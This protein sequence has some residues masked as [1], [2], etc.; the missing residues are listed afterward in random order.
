LRRAE[1][2]DQIG[3]VLRISSPGDPNAERRVAIRLL[4]NGA[5]GVLAGCG[6]NTEIWPRGNGAHLNAQRQRK[7]QEGAMKVEPGKR[8]ASNQ[9]M[10][11][12]QEP[13]EQ[14]LER[15]ADFKKNLGPFCRHIGNEAGKLN[16]IAETLLSV[17]KDALSFEGFISPLGLAE[18]TLLVHAEPGGFPAILEFA[19][20]VS[21]V[22]PIQK[23]YCAIYVYLGRLAG[24]R[25]SAIE[26]AK[27]LVEMTEMLVRVSQ[28]DPGVSVT[29]IEAAR[30]EQVVKG[31]LMQA[32]HVEGS[33]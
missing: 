27:R 29:R 10:S 33:S 18:R 21:K 3:T 12:F 20:A 9:N 8:L 1:A 31:L 2:S 25:K 32:D 6:A 13:G 11:R 30:N 23:N 19:P 26:A 14:F 4:L 17:E 5:P 28:I 16:C 24:Q 15:R 7:A 22:S